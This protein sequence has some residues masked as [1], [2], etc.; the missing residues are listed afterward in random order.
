MSNTPFAI[1]DL[2]TTTKFSY[3]R[4]ANPFDPENWIVMAGALEAEE[5]WGK[6]YY[7][8]N[9]EESHKHDWFRSL[10]KRTK[11]LVGFNFKF[12][13]HH[14]IQ[15]PENYVAWMD[16]IASGGQI[17]DCQL[18]EYLLNGMG[19]QDQYL[20]LDEVAPRY[21]GN[22][23]VDEV[24]LLWEDGVDTPDIDR[25]LLERYLVGDPKT[26]DEGDL[27]NTR[28]IFRGQLAR[29]RKNGQL[30]SLLLNMGSL[31]YTIEAEHQGMAVDYELGCKLAA[32]REQELAAL[33]EELAKFIPDDLPFEFNWGSRNHLSALIFG[34]QVKYVAKAPILDDDGNLVYYQK[35]VVHYETEDGRFIEAREY[36][37]KAADEPEHAPK[38]KRYASGKKKGE[39]KTKK[40]KVPDLERGPKERNEDFYYTFP[41]F[42]KPR[43][44]WE[45]KTPGVYSTAAD[46]IEALGNCGIPFLKTLAEHSAVSKDLKTYFITTDEKTG[47][48]K[49]MLTLV[50]NG[51]IHHSLNHV[52]TVTG[53]F[54]S[55]N[56]NLQNLSGK[57]KS[58]VKSLF[59][60]RYPNGKVIQSDF[61]SLE[62]YIQAVLTGCRQLIDDLKA[63]LDMHCLRVSQKERIPYEEAVLKCKGSDTVEPLPEWEKKR[64]GAKEF[65]FQ[66]AYGAGIATIAAATGMDEDEVQALADAEA[67]RY[68]EIEAYFE[69][70]TLAIE[71]STKLTGVK[72][73]HPDFPAK[74]VELGRGFH[75]TPDGK[76]YSWRQNPA[77]KYIVE[78]S[79]KWASYS[80]P[81][82]KNY[83]VQ[84]GGAEWAKA[85]MWLAVRAFYKLRNFEGRAVLVN[86][87]HDACYADAAE[88][89]APKAA[90]LLHVAMEHASPFIESYF[91]WP[92]PVYVPSDTTWGDSMIE[93]KKPEGMADHLPWA[94]QLVES[95]YK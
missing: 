85:A 62:I 94:T 38:L 40:F 14:L 1:I 16:W 89:V 66:R 90:A 47:E 57:G 48:K 6:A 26:G 72:V 15:C 31:V 92:Q 81:E 52:N 24:K 51:I 29:A 95:F 74:I 46:T 54:S 50:D 63:G 44:E 84:G 12:D 60:S 23:K 49:G 11:L 35:E 17:F 10:L 39:P 59:V 61:T 18:A 93:E 80:P 4:K 25:D 20:S 88:E 82:V 91:N 2:E 87:V 64:K 41:G 67:E 3:K 69:R 43:K 56:P 76:L 36:E 37:A 5:R 32:E 42:T 71:Q 53:R 21:G 86:Q 70:I 65:S 27:G 75:R 22:L 83:E 7:Y 30:K 79:G 33:T 55:S 77:P 68:P 19:A 13:I 58:K 34:G 73:P 9:R 78:R 28:L 8:L 45:T